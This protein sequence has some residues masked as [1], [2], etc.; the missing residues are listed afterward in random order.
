MSQDT[1]PN[2]YVTKYQETAI[3]KYQ[4][5][6]YMLKGTV[7]D[8]G[9][10]NGNTVKWMIAGVGA[11]VPL[12]R[13]DKGPAMNASRGSVQQDMQQWQAN[14]WVYEDDIEKLTVNEMNVVSET[15]GM[16]IGRRSD[17][18]IINELNSASL[19]QVGNGSTAFGLV[20]ALT[21]IQ[22]LQSVDVNW[23]G[24]V[25]CA[26]PSL[27]WNQLMSFKQ[28]NDSDWIGET[29]LPYT[30]NT[31]A[32]KWNG[33][34][35]FLVSDSYFPVP[36]ANQL[37]FFMWHKKAVG[38]GTNYAL[39]TNVTWENLYSGWYHNNRFSACA[40]VLLPEGAIRFRYASNSA[41]TIN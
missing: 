17:L 6:G 24:D 10:I 11:A 15:A 35:W 37:D 16:A 23:D 26:M 14:D 40:K 38:F 33:V 3:L 34:N 28:F 22:K 21:G 31:T 5:K 36:A 30:K 8:A 20:D 2:W 25:Y 9:S 1:A 19:V 7:T 18:I 27:F 32:K 12:S 29:D 4:A 41:I 13:G 39:R